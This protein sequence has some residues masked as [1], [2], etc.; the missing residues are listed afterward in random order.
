MTS[1]KVIAEVV[2]PD[3]EI[4]FGTTIDPSLADEMKVTVNATS[5]PLGRA[6]SQRRRHLRRLGIISRLT[7]S[8][9]LQ[10]R[11]FAVLR[12]AAATR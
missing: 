11:S 4:I 10:T 6:R 1:A 5:L 9:T 3:A 8:A 2:A 7:R 12:R